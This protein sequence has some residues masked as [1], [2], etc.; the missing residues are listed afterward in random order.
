MKSFI[1]FIILLSSLN[2]LNSV[3]PKWELEKIATKLTTTFPYSYVAYEDD[4]YEFHLILTR[5]ICKNG[6]TL[7]Y[8]TYVQINN[9]NNPSDS[10]S[11]DVDFDTVGSFFHVRE[12]YYICPKG[13]HH[14][15]DLTGK[16]YVTPKNFEENGGLDYELKCVYHEKSRCF[17]AFYEMNGEKAFYPVYIDNDMNQMELK[18][19][20]GN[21]FYDLRIKSEPYNDNNEY[22]LLAL[23]KLGN[24]ISLNTFGATLQ[25]GYQGVSSQKS[26][27]YYDVYDNVIGTFRNI[28]SDYKYDFFYISYND[29]SN[30]KSGYTTSTLG[31]NWFDYTKVIVKD[32]GIAHLEFF[33][34]L[35]IEE[36]KFMFYNRYMYYKFKIPGSSKAKYY[37]IF[38]TKLNKVIFNTD[39]YIE[40]FLPHSETE[41]LALTQSEAYVICAMKD[42]STGK[43]VDYCSEEKYYLDTEG[44][45][46][47][48]PE[49]PSDKIMFVPS[50]VCI[51]SCDLDYY[52]TR[53]NTCGLCKYFYP[54]D[55]PYT[56][57]G[58]NECLNEISLSN[59]MEVYN[60]KLKIY[61][62]I[63]GYKA[64]GNKCVVD[65]DC[66]ENC[67]ECTNTACTKCNTSYFLNDG[68]CQEHCSKG[69]S[70]NSDNECEDCNKKTCSNFEIDSCDCTECIESTF[71]KNKNCYDCDSSCKTCEEEATKCTSCQA[72]IQFLE[73]NKCYDCGDGNCET[74]EANCKCKS[75]KS[76]F[77]LN[78]NY[79]CESCI[80]DCA[81]CKDS[82]TCDKCKDDF[83]INT[84][85]KCAKCP[86]SCATK[87]PGSCQ[88]ATCKEGYFMNSDEECQECIS[89]CNSCEK[90]ANNCTSC[91]DGYF[92]NEI[93]EC[94]QCDYSKCKTCS[95]N[96]EHCESCNDGLYL[97][98]ENNTC[99]NCDEHC[100]TCSSG[101][102]DGNYNCLSCKND[103]DSIYKYRIY[104]DYNQTCVENCTDY[105]REFVNNSFDC[106]PLRKN[107]GTNPDGNGKESETDY[108]LW[109]FIAVIAILL[110]IITICICKKCFGD[111]SNSEIM[112]EISTEL[113]EKELT[114]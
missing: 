60:L 114:N 95:L 34:D 40:Y 32:N 105:G 53:N 8:T 16:G 5:K 86:D 63:N 93:R 81:T 3:I 18:G 109:I 38:D 4:W 69:K 70:P 103:T 22:Y 29:L 12:R 102:E 84:E 101:E 89:P 25:T 45:K 80:S 87:K 17:L 43:C 88:C 96:K 33:E 55:Y 37:G 82:K 112:E 78:S 24:K 58:S 83:Y 65:K 7:N 59:T 104:D 111:K 57:M 106:K 28:N 21:E 2:L 68:V 75:C 90:S 113:D 10:A 107:N 41:M 98:K 79:K 23:N 36:I 6:D 30:L 1:Y 94:A 50:G 74:K 11:N 19:K 97:V 42:E 35:E 47:G 54:D 100:E 67:L 108:L 91:I 26:K 48:S 56:L 77:F 51:P 72:E 71:L 76:G 46:C 27:P 44:N 13:R 73:N 20:L 15:Y 110:I 14:V 49:C 62:C 92:M 61:K 64:S 39:E 99:Q 52:V 85:G 66:P 9:T 31:D